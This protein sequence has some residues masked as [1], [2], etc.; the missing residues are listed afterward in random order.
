MNIYDPQSSISS[1]LRLT[2]IR[3]LMD[4]GERISFQAGEM[5]FHEGDAC[6]QVYIIL[7]GEAEI[8]KNDIHGNGSVIATAQ[9]GSV[10]GE[11]G[12]FLDLRR[13]GSVMAKTP[14]TLI[15]LKNDDFIGALQ[16]FPD[17]SLRLFKSLSL[18]L[19]SANT[20][21]SALSNSL[22]MVQLGNYILESPTDEE[23]MQHHEFYAIMANSE[24]KRHEITTV[25]T[26]FK[27]MAIIDHLELSADGH[28]AFQLDAGQLRHYLQHL[29][30][31]SAQA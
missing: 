16:Q 7:S 1:T 25:L 12:L 17:L 28:I 2:T 3:Y 26:H 15:A 8:I 23:G 18:K 27:Q 6:Q 11:M 22:H 24:L 10:F 20:R 31:H 30:T 14:L 4:F 5:V 21:F 9:Q 19:D 29:A 13:S